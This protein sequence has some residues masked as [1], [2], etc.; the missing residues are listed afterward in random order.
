MEQRISL[1]LKEQQIVP[2][3]FIGCRVLHKLWKEFFNNELEA[4]P[5]LFKQAF[6]MKFGKDIMTEQRKR[7][8]F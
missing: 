1:L 3:S 5:D 2:T 8:F 6:D 4:D 7:M